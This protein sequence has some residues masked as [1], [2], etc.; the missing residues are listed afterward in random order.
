MGL[1]PDFPTDPYAI[2]DPA[3]RW[4][5]GEAMLDEMGYEMLLPPL[6]HKVR[7]GVRAWRDRGYEGA[8][9]TTK[10]LLNH[11][12]NSE[13]LLPQVNGGK[14]RWYFAQREAVESAIWLYEVERARDPYAL[15][16]YN[17]SGRI[18]KGMFVQFDLTATPRHNKG[19]IFVQTV[20]DYPLVEAIRQQVVKTPVLPDEASRA[21][22][23]ARATSSPSATRT[24]CTSATW[25]GR[26]P[27]R[28]F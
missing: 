3:V 26:R 23:N 10:A 7:H 27:T 25:N 11:W 18:S 19:G 4:Y 15:M 14:F 9:A 17:S 24:T 20:S 13:H 16:K 28:N 2:M 22:K 21:K 6:V 12:F 5:P 1:H 8:S